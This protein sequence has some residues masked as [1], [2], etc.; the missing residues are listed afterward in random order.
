LQFRFITD[1]ENPSMPPKPANKRTKILERIR[2][3]IEHSKESRYAI[4]KATGI[5][6]STLSKL[7]SGN[8]GLSVE[9]LDAMF[10]YFGLEITRRRGK[11]S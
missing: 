4:A 3:E 10:E 5:A 11:R 9:A 6:E 8:R 2:E 1:A 7:M